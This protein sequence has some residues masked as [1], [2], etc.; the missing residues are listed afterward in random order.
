MILNIGCGSQTFGD[1]KCDIYPSEAADIICDALYLPFRSECFNIVYSKTVFEHLNNPLNALTEQKRV[2]RRGGQ[3]IVITDN[4][5]Y[6]R[7][8]MFPN[9]NHLA[10][11][12]RKYDKHYGLYTPL[13]LQNFFSDLQLNVESIRFIKFGTTKVDIVVQMMAKVVKPLNLM[14]YPCIEAVATKP[15]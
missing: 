14:A 2:L 7:F 11:Q 6:W 1:I 10:Y 9:G 13:H 15:N 12:T 8:Y 3:I 4:S 5:G